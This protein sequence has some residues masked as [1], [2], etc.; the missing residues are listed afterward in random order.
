MMRPWYIPPANSSFFRRM[1][2]CQWNISDYAESQPCSDG[3]LHAA[4]LERSGGEVGR[5]I[6]LLQISPGA[7]AI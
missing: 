6:A 1:V 3:H 7:D 2:K 5:R 4:D